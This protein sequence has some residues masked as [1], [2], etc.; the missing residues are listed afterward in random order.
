MEIKQN[1]YK[2]VFL[3]LTT[4]IQFL[5]NFK[6][7]YCDYFIL[8][9]VHKFSM[10]LIGKIFAFVILNVIFYLIAEAIGPTGSSLEW[11]HY[12]IQGGGVILS[13]IILYKLSSFSKM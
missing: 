3:N 1:S 13:L 5:L 2:Q 11:V 7:V 4:T 10:G 8:L 9:W 12:P 6:C